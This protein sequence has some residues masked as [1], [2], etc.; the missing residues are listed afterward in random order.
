MTTNESRGSKKI[1]SGGCELSQAGQTHD[2]S[3]LN[4]GSRNP[5]FLRGAR[6]VVGSRHG[7]RKREGTFSDVKL[8]VHFTPEATRPVEKQDSR[9]LRLQHLDAILERLEQLNLREQQRVTVRDEELYIALV[10]LGIDD[11]VLRR[12]TITH[13]IELI[14]QRQEAL[15]Y[16]RLADGVSTEAFTRKKRSKEFIE[17][18]RQRM[19][20]LNEEK[21]I[22]KLSEEKRLL[23]QLR[24]QRARGFT[25]IESRIVEFELR[26]RIQSLMKSAL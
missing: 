22:L 7:Q 13:L 15:L 21:R 6:G 16:R 26:E 1:S 12:K 24:A 5:S 23:E 20:K 2:Y 4:Q 14:W 11:V 19:L 10:E 8:P 17:N 18:Q 9:K 25:T 3:S